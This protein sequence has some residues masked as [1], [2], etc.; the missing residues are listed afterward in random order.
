MDTRFLSRE[1]SLMLNPPCLYLLPWSTSEII[2]HQSKQKAEIFCYAAYVKLGVYQIS[3]Q[4][5]NTN[6]IDGKL[7]TSWAEPRQDMA[8][9][10]YGGA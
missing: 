5:N 8:W 2:L 7:K 9:E 6:K 10:G 1:E 4:G 3:K